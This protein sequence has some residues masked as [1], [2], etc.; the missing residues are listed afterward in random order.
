MTN[1]HANLLRATGTLARRTP[2]T[3]NNA[4]RQPFRVIRLALVAGCVITL[5]QGCKPAAESD[6]KTESTLDRIR[7]QKVVRIGYANEAPFAYK[8]SKTGRLTGEA[9]E[10][11]RVIFRQMGVEEVE[12]VLTEFGSLIPGLKAGRFDVI[13][14]GMYITPERGKEIAFSNPSY[15]IGEAFAVLKGNPKNLHSYEDVVAHKSATLGVVAGTVERGYA[16]AVGIP[17]E[18]IIVFP[19]APSAIEGVRAKR[20]DAFA[21]TSL[22]IQDLLDKEATGA[23]ERALPFTDPV[24]KGKTVRGYGAFGFRKDDH[25]LLQRFNEGLA[26]LVGTPEH[27]AL[28]RPFGFTIDELPG[29]ITA[30]ALCRSE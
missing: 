9:P 14:A 2:T 5:M 10:I 12:G 20:V 18:R 8:D 11:A 22:T 3:P 15:S 30:E 23:V 17:D 28:V 19:G 7:R 26:T 4:R 25:L 24:I 13:A 6:G 29:R 27:A 16:R 21:G 1:S